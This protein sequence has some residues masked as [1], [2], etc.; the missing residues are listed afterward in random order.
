MYHIFG[1]QFWA[2]TQLGGWEAK[3]AVHKEIMEDLC[4]LLVP[5]KASNDSVSLI[6]TGTSGALFGG[7]KSI[8]GFS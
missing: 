3:F 1:L 4:G 7:T 8:S 2:F 6:K 5:W